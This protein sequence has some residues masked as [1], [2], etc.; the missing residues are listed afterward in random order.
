MKVAKILAATTLLMAGAAYAGPYVQLQYYDEETR[1]TK[2]DDYKLGLVFG[3]TNPD[4]T[5]YSIKLETN[6]RDF[7]EFGNEGIFE[8]R[9]RKSFDSG[10]H[11]FEPYVGLRIGGRFGKYDKPENIWYYAVDAGVKFPIVSNW[12]SGDVG[13]RYRN[14]FGG[15]DG[16]DSN[17]YHVGVSYAVTKQD[18]VSLRY[19]QSYGDVTQEKNS[20]RLAYTHSF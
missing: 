18:S 19:S 13:Y 4:K 7:Y 20:W 12:L 16:F 6:K 5:D 14:S 11:N 10:F 2:S 17:R 8:G 9:A 3:Q 15:G 1:S